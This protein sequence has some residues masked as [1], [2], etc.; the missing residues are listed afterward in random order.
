MSVEREA[1]KFAIHAHG[2][3]VRK[4]DPEKPY[5]VHP[6]HVAY[7]LRSYGFDENVVAAGYLHDVVEDTPYEKEDL[8]REFG[9]DITSL[10]MRASQ[11]DK[12]LSWEERKMQAINAVCGQDLRHKAVVCADK[13]S[14]VD[15][16][17]I[18]FGILQRHDYSLFNR[19]YDKQKWYV[20]MMYEKLVQGEDENKFMF[21]QF[22]TL[23][24]EVFHSNQMFSHSTEYY[25]KLEL[26]KL[27]T[28][29]EDIQRIGLGEQ[30]VEEPL[31][32]ETMGDDFGFYHRRDAYIQKIKKKLLKVEE[33]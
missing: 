15:D 13:I 19:G 29:L 17:K 20:D 23:L 7:L 24:Q 25:Q 31:V 27:K 26:M 10:V 12:K 18:Q 28:I 32:P 6:I 5:I 14:N 4:A 30:M 3:A 1:L 33:D 8:L 21:S 22:Y 2:K 11:P 9:E 16:F